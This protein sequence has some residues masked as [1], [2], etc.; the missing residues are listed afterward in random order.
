MKKLKDYKE[1]YYFYTGKTSEINRSF[2][3]SGIAIIWIFNKTSSNKIIELPFE[4]I[5]PLTLFFWSLFVDVLQYFFGGIIWYLFYKY[6]ECK[7][8]KDEDEL[9]AHEV[10]PIPIHLLYYTKIILSG[11][12]FYYL[13]SFLLAQF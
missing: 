3:L 12:G 1:D 7:S 2:V 5:L 13:I 8:V 9:E 10:L 6:N 4:L 11:L